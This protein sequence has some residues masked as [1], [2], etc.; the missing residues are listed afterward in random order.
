MPSIPPSPALHVWIPAI[1]V[2]ARVLPVD[3]TP[4]GAKNAWGGEVFAPINF[5][6]DQDVRQ[7][8]RRGD[9]NSLPA[10]QSSGSVKAFDRTVL[11]GHASDM[12]N[13]L[14]FQELSSL[15][16]GDSVTVNTTLGRF[17]YTVTN[18][19]TRAKA[20]L[21]D[22]AALY[23]YPTDGKK[24]LALV[25]CLPDATSNVVVFATLTTARVLAN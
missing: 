19:V 22:L 6:V 12:G 21:N 10:A 2:N 3:S 20:N 25:A 23:R 1:S 16:A 11:Y 17:V 4:T 8:I 7:W 5:P 9:P 15:R 24:E 14:V 18:V 13:H